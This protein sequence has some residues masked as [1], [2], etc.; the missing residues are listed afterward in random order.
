MDVF[1]P[2]IKRSSLRFCLK[3]LRKAGCENPRVIKNMLWVDACNRMAHDAGA[4]WFLRVDDDMLICKW[5]IEFI[6][7]LI[8]ENPNAGMVSCNLYDWKTKTPMRGVK[9]YRADVTRTL[10]FRADDNGRV[11]KIFAHR[12]AEKSVPSIISEV[13]V[14]IHAHTPDREQ[15]RSWRMRGERSLVK[16]DSLVGQSCN[17]SEQMLFLEH[18]VNPNHG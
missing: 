1:V 18:L 11:D 16:Y 12:L 3:A 8:A 15:E 4:E 9:A 5:G 14:G 6:K 13:V 17:Y 2:T 7:S 10:G